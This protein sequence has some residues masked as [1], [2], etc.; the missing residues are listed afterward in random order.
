M[1]KKA[2]DLKESYIEQIKQQH[3][4]RQ[5]TW[6]VDIEIWLIFG[7]K[8]KRDRDNYHKMT[9]DSLQDTVLLDDSQIIKATVTKQY[10]PKLR[11][12]NITI[13]DAEIHTDS[14]W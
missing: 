4:N 2:K 5:H 9:M 12:T 7:D 6:P 8:V 10:I 13:T 3:T 11:I 14:I 1:T